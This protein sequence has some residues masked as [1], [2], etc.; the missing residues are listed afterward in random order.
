MNVD[1]DGR[2][3][4]GS[5][6]RNR[7]KIDS[8]GFY[9]EMEMVE[10]A[11]KPEITRSRVGELKR[12]VVKVL[13][14]HPEGLQAKN[15]LLE[16]AQVVPPTEFEA[17]DY[18]N[19]PGDRRYEKIVRFASI[20]LVKAGWMTKT[21][22][23]WALTEDGKKAFDQYRDPEEFERESFRLYK[24]WEAS[25]ANALMELAQGE[26]EAALALEKVVDDVGTVVE[27]EE[28]AW[29]QIEKHINLLDG[30]EFQELVKHLLQAMGYHVSW[31]AS[32]GKDGGVDIMAHSDPLGTSTPR[33]MVQ[34]K[35]QV[36]SVDAKDLRSFQAVVGSHDV[37]LFVCS[38]GFTKEAI[39]EARK[40][41]TCRVTLLDL[42]QLFDQWVK[43]YEK[44]SETGK[45]Y[46]PIR[47]I[48]YLDSR[49]G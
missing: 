1:K 21:K 22:G 38:G 11:R 33:I 20:D 27:A 14:D 9:L 46:L 23:K 36:S 16:L 4:T 44:I 17:T 6:N 45:Q 48:Y 25:Q 41:Q 2:L 24:Q 42:E 7:E 12:G 30:Y 39:A 31:V 40:N 43:H 19:R 47:P 8:Y 34:V 37:G 29:S 26:P 49:K 35:R 5:R 28:T 3:S 18:P 10:T 13:L 15:T 32:K